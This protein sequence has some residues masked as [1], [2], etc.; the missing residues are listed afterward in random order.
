MHSQEMS[1]HPSEEF[2]RRQWAHRT[3]H[4]ETTPPLVS[5]I[6]RTQ[7][8]LSLLRDALTSVAQQTYPRLEVILVN[9]G[10]ADVGPVVDDFRSSLD[11][12]LSTHDRPAGRAAAANTGL[13]AVRGTLIN[14]LD[15]DDRLYPHH[16][17]R[18]VLFL[19]LTGGQFAYSDCEMGHYQAAEGGYALVGTRLSYGGANFDPDRLLLN[20]YIPLM[21]AM[22]TR[23]L[24]TEVG[25]FDKSLAILEDW[26]YWL[27]AAQ[28]T[29]FHHLSGITAE[30][31]VFDRPAYDYS[32]WKQMVLRKHHGGSAVKMSLVSA[33]SRIEVL[34]TEH[35]RV[36]SG[37]VE[38]EALRPRSATWL[39]GI[40]QLPRGWSVRAGRIV[41]RLMVSGVRLLRR[42]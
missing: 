35:A 5:I 30:Y 29:P 26:D 16:V 1:T 31:R 21:T 27:R 19:Q 25:L 12:Q 20:N 24:A 41:Q 4:K 10:G 22:F 23:E 37:R 28:V 15:D 6:I 14:F 39:A 36:S 40:R 2:A 42:C 38:Q 32:P 9:D 8:R 7:D 11:I 13:R 17:E 3:E 34:Q 33:L 18:L